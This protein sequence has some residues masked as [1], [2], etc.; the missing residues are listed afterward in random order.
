[1]SEQWTIKTG[2]ELQKRL[3]QGEHLEHNERGYFLRFSHERVS[4]AAAAEYRA[5][6]DRMR[7]ELGIDAPRLS[8]SR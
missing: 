7:S 8:R 5:R 2:E 3:R 6:I 4:P 1:M